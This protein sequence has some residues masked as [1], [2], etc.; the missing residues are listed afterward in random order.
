MEYRKISKLHKWYLKYTDRPAYDL[1]K[2]SLKDYDFYQRTV[3]IQHPPLDHPYKMLTSFK[4][5]GNSGDIIYSLPTVFELAKN[6][7]AQIYL[8][9]GEVGIYQDYHPLGGVMLNDKV[10][11]ML[12]PLLSY[13]PRIELCEKYNGEKIDYDLDQ[14]RTYG[15]LMDRGSIVKWYYYVYGISA[16]SSVPWLTAPVDHHYADYLVVARSHRYRQPMIDYSFLKKYP[17]KI[18]VGVPEEYEDMKKVLPDIEYRPVKDFL[19]MA[20]IIT[21]C[22]LFIGNQSFPFS[23]AEALKANRLLEVYYKA[24]NVIV[25][26]RGGNDFMYQPQFE[27]MVKKAFAG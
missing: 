19:E 17:K 1:Y 20:T 23:I 26:G 6:G 18:F 4:H 15:I 24:P 3:Q 11:Q 8:N 14:F 27:Y 21:S 10:I 12:K 16:D 7:K 22:R 5:S 25:E 2:R 13:Q 9:E